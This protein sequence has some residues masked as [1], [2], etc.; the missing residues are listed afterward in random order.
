[1]HQTT[2]SSQKVT[3]NWFVELPGTVPLPRPLELFV[4]HLRSHHSHQPLFYLQQKRPTSALPYL[5]QDIACISN[6]QIDQLY[7]KKNKTGNLATL[8]LGHQRAL[9]PPV[10]FHTSCS[11]MAFQTECCPWWYIAVS[12]TPGWPGQSPPPD[13]GSRSDLQFSAF[14]QGWHLARSFS[15]TQPFLLLQ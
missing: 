10:P 1:M 8:P 15:Q 11:H 13:S 12:R 14:L 4:L 6:R 3:N 9:K 7:I 5:I 2:Y